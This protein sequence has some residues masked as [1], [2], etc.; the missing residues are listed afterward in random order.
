MNLFQLDILLQYVNLDPRKQV[1][2]GA[3]KNLRDLAKKGA[4]LWTDKHV[5]VSEWKNNFFSVLILS[6]ALKLEI[7]DTERLFSLYVYSMF[8]Y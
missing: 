2:F 5:L 6:I 8:F 4:H 7:N 1:K 3:L